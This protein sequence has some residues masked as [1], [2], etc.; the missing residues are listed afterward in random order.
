M[1]AFGAT[2]DPAPKVGGKVQA[3]STTA[4]TLMLASMKDRA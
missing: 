1:F 3:I 2:A 4:D